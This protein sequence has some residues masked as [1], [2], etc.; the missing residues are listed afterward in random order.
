MNIEEKI[1]LDVTYSVENFVRN[2]EEKI[3]LDVTYS[4]ENFVRKGV[5]NP[6]S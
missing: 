3:R 1:R 6:L 4:V 5:W 2:I